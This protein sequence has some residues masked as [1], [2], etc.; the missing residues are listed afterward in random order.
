MI[1]PTVPPGATVARPEEWKEA[2][3]Q[4]CEWLKTAH[5][6][7]V[8]AFPQIDFTRETPEIIKAQEKLEW[9][10]WAYFYSKTATMSDVTEAWKT[11]YKLFLPEQQKT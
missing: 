6:A 5:R 8:G 7:V 10:I 11:Y 2:R 3:L 1:E 9:Y 4:A